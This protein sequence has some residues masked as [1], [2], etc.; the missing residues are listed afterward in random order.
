[1]ST[2]FFDVMNMYVLD[3]D[4]SHLPGGDTREDYLPMEDD[5]S[6]DSNAEVYQS[7]EDMLY[8]T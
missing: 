2:L 5:Y 4:W 8:G 6:E 3:A 7:L 1:M